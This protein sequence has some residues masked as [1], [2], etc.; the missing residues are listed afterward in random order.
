MTAPRH[1]VS[2]VRNYLAEPS[3]VD[4]AC[5]SI[6]AAYNQLKSSK[7]QY[8][9]SI[10]VVNSI[11]TGKTHAA[12]AFCRENRAIYIG[13]EN[14]G[15]PNPGNLASHSVLMQSM[16]DQVRGLTRVRDIQSFI[17]KIIHS[18][19][20]AA[21]PYATA[22][23]LY[24]AQFMSTAFLDN[25]RPK[26]REFSKTTPSKVKSILSDIHSVSEEAAPVTRT[27][28][29]E[30]LAAK[31]EVI[32]VIDEAMTLS[33][34]VVAALR[35]MSSEYENTYVL[36]LS[37]SSHLDNLIPEHLP[38]SCESSGFQR[39]GRAKRTDFPPVV[40]EVA[41]NFY[42]VT[43]YY[44]SFTFGRAL[45]SSLFKEFGA[46]PTYALS[47]VRFACRLLIPDDESTQYTSL[48]LFGCRFS[49][50]AF[51]QL[52]ARLVQ[53]HLAVV[54]EVLPGPSSHEMICCY[55][56]EP[57]LA[58]AATLLMWTQNLFGVVLDNLFS[59]LTTTSMMSIN[60]GDLG[61]VM[62]FVYICAVLDEL[63]LKALAGGYDGHALSFL[64]GIYIGSFLQAITGQ[65]HFGTELSS[66]KINCTHAYRPQKGEIKFTKNAILN[67]YARGCALYA[68]ACHE[69]IDLVIPLADEASKG[70]G[71][72]LV[73]VKN[74]KTKITS[75]GARKILDDIDLSTISTEEGVVCVRLMLGV[76]R[77]GTEGIPP[78]TQPRSPRSCSAAAHRP[79]SPI[80]AS[81]GICISDRYS[82]DLNEIIK[83]ILKVLTQ[84]QCSKQTVHRTVEASIQ[85]DFSIKPALVDLKDFSK[86]TGKEA[87]NKQMLSLVTP[88]TSS[89]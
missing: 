37:T 71:L 51:R 22:M 31:Q 56:P 3:G 75:D 79:A 76:G 7:D 70:V 88:L 44:H 74:W 66:L 25:L 78:P 15:R 62:A 83:R 30:P 36:L 60:V 84:V 38:G 59:H 50:T 5:N 80:E 47:L 32:L 41:M 12:T 18:L 27:Q 6:Q 4:P 23:E 29:E 33:K 17:G 73:Q 52:A 16:F 45:W 8:Y 21:E 2:I 9:H 11:G 53:G 86:D 49:L 1:E 82:G 24:N 26:W 68:V 65:D 63:K 42:S 64:R 87:F 54:L 48:A 77:G 28:F 89:E 39:H 40:L 61:E 57:V 81:C 46:D 43:P 55:F 34:E 13:L 58:E 85:P 69:G 19:L 14:S 67:L 20:E 10:V 35:R 72:L